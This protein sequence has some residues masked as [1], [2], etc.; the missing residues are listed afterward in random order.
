MI[1]KK[2]IYITQ[3]AVIAALYAALTLALAPIS[4][5]PI[6]FRIAEAL[7]IMPV[8]TSAAIPGLSIG[9]LISNA[10]GMAMGTNVAGALDILFGTAATLSA[11]I[12]TCLL[13]KIKWA[14]LP[15]LAM[16]PPVILNVLIIGTE[17]SIALNIPIWLT[18]LDV[19]LG[20]FVSCCIIGAVLYFV[21]DKLDPRIKKYITL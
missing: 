7:T 13:R 21:I 11:A 17:L 5:G 10:I 8:F 6:Q 19:L 3:A 14:K 20:Q 1:S 9:C 15:I 12:L 2:I 18:M 4:F 16:L